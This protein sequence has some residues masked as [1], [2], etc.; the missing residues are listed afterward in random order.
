M[1][2]VRSNARALALGAFLIGAAATTA[3]AQQPDTTKP[4]AADSTRRAP[5]DSRTI[6]HQCR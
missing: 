3:P 5:A 4:P 6:W 1:Y 2:T